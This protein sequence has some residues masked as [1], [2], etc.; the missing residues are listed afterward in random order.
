MKPKKPPPD[1]RIMKIRDYEDRLARL[2]QSVKVDTYNGAVASWENASDKKLEQL[3][4]QQ[5][6]QALR[7]QRAQ[8]LDARRDKLAYKLHSEELALKEELLRIQETPEERR[9]KM[10][11]RARELAALREAERQ[12][13][14]QELMDRAFRANCDPLRELQTKQVICRTTADRDRQIE[15]KMLQRALAQEEK[16]SYDQMYEL[17]R[18]KKEQRYLDDKRREKEQKAETQR[19]LDEQVRLARERSAADM[20]STRREVDEL[21]AS[22]RRMEEEASAAESLERERLRR[23]AE[24]VRAWNELR[25]AEMS[26]RE[27]LE[28]EQDLRVLSDALAREAADELRD[29]EGRRRKQE[30]VRAHRAALASMMQRQ[31]EDDG[32]RDRLVAADA[33]ARQAAADAEVAAREAARAAL[34]AEVDA[35]RQ[36][37]IAEKQ[38]ARQRAMEEQL[39]ERL[40]LEE[41]AL[42]ADDEAAAAR[43]AARRRALAARL[44]LETQAVAKEALARADAT[45]RLSE[46][47][48]AAVREEE[49]VRQ[50][51]AAGAA[52][53]PPQ[54]F[55][56]KKV[57]WFH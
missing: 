32:E 51:E 26:E 7:A 34:M 45:E 25:R 52:V 27:R 57:E 48:T 13:L 20:A 53:D 33:A 56:R 40:A 14:A 3:R 42:A 9:A 19:H 29:Q 10:G 12:Q 24:E 16:Q 21:K 35:I 38:A 17:E 39:A 41:G 2:Q 15:E 44:D 4:E 23:L 28:R 36:R 31:A 54:W 22:W 11:Q 55:G 47:H 37:Q 46:R 43:V 30:E 18:L 49:Y 6:I 5:E 8:E 50:V 1:A